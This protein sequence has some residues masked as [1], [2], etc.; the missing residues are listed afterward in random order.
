MNYSPTSPA[1]ILL[2]DDHDLIREGLA[3]LLGGQ[4]DLQ[5]VGQAHDGLEALTLV[6][7]L[8][9]DLIIMDIKMPVCDGL[10]ATRLI[11]QE[12]PEARIVMLTVHDEETKLFEAIKAGACG[13]MLKNSPSSQLLSGVRGALLGEAPISPRLA[14]SLLD[15]FARLSSSQTT[16][17]Q[18]SPGSARPLIEIDD[19]AMLLTPRERDILNHLASGATDKEIANG[20]SLSIHTVKSHVRSILSKLHAVN[21]RHAA[22][23]AGQRG[24]LGS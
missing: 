5:V 17:R 21:R 20:T 10:E 4:P 23:L 7:D 8:R 15:E 9:P 16:G 13:Y 24:L 3:A 22:Q 6:R 12:L 2:C 14:A 19:P 18:P 11:R 1:R